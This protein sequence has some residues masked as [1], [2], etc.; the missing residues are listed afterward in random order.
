MLSE[1]RARL[2]RILK[3]RKQLDVGRLGWFS[4]AVIQEGRAKETHGLNKLDIKRE[5]MC[6]FNRFDSGGSTLA[7]LV[8]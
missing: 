1:R 4:W 5:P 6:Y 2:D 8:H 3:Q 7:S